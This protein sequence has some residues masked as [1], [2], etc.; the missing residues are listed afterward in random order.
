MLFYRN[1][2]LVM[3][4]SQIAAVDRTIVIYDKIFR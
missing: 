4:Q 3:N 1:K 2:F